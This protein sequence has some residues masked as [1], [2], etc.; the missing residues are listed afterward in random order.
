[1][2]LLGF[3]SSIARHGVCHL[4]SNTR[5]CDGVW[6]HTDSPTEHVSIELGRVTE[7]GTSDV[8]RLAVCEDS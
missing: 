4:E 1:M 8:G 5:P 2:G 6:A 7:N 3:G